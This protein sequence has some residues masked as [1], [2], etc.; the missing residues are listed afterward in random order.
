[1]KKPFPEGQISRDSAAE[2]SRDELLRRIASLTDRLAKAE[3]ALRD[4]GRNTGERRNAPFPPTDASFAKGTNTRETRIDDR[5]RELAAMNRLLLDEIRER[6]SAEEDLRESESRFRAIYDT[7]PV[8]IVLIDAKGLVEAANPAMVSMLGMPPQRILGRPF[9]EFL[10]RGQKLPRRRIY[11]DLVRRKKA[12]ADLEIRWTDP[13]GTESWGR[14]RLSLYS[15]PWDS[16]PR[17][18][19]S[20]IDVTPQKR[21]EQSQSRN[22]RWQAS[23]ADLGKRTLGRMDSAEVLAD[24]VSL[25]ARQLRAPLCGYLAIA[26]DRP[27]FVLRAGV[28]LREG[29]PGEYRLGPGTESQAGFTLMT[30]MPVAA[31][32]L[33]GETRFRPAEI[34]LS[35][36]ARSGLTVPVLGEK[37]DPYGVLGIY[38]LKKRSFSPAEKGFLV[39]VAQI[40]GHFLERDRIEK[41]LASAEE[42]YR[43][44]V[45][46]IPAITYLATAGENIAPIYVSPQIRALGYSPEEWVGEPS[47]HLSRI[48]PDDRSRVVEEYRRCIET[49]RP[50]RS[51][52]RLLARD[53]RL[54]WFHNEA[55]PIRRGNGD[56]LFWQGVMIDNT[57]QKKAEENL[58]LSEERLQILL[59]D[60][61]LEVF[62]LRRGKIVFRNREQ[63]AESGTDDFRRSMTVVP[64]DAGRFEG[65]C[66]AV[67]RKEGCVQHGDVR[68]E[69]DS[70]KY[71]PAVRWLRIETSPVRFDNEDAT[72]VLVIDITEAK[73][74]EQ[75]ILA[76]EKLA[77]LGVMTAGIAHEIRNPLS[78]IA[79]YAG[80]IDHQLER[81]SGASSD[82]N[83]TLRTI[84][85][86]ISEGTD[87]ISR[88]IQRIMDFAK[89]SSPVFE[90]TDI[91][92]VVEEVTRLLSSTVRLGKTRLRKSLAADI[93][94][95]LADPAL[96]KQVLINLVTNSLQAV[97]E[98]EGER[99]IEIATS[100]GN[101]EVVVIHDDS[102][103]GIPEELRE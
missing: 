29:I 3:D 57:D 85:R 28:G 16:P 103:P 73:A 91:N 72:L 42:K 83:E 17:I 78:G 15:P 94:T 9:H 12:V 68:V 32:D 47:L 92:V 21:L 59:K 53:G 90:P 79:L 35:H 25:V 88:V 60:L 41:N 89:P 99:H 40:L 2:R 65:I 11:V 6:F 49:G 76:K 67:A 38:Y 7:V 31:P 101:G 58:R 1:M 46:R 23:L 63:E 71:G 5:A 24:A 69:A 19:C 50:F 70:P 18:L 100:A 64:E 102:G 48:H 80:A 27:G 33:A 74:M 61:P 95:C 52:Y 8:G 13:K 37:G 22:L 10:A 51:E 77:S 43:T 45:E 14:A 56:T 55:G 84:T 86:K 4:T 96:L 26:E 36:K 75:H 82:P 62:I 81:M 54:L 30:G 66:E 44:L 39:S 93:P 97:K 20:V 34:L 87:R 98:C